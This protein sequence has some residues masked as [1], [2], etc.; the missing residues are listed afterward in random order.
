MT[1][2]FIFVAFALVS[3][4]LSKSQV[5]NQIPPPKP[6]LTVS[7]TPNPTEN[8][9]TYTNEILNISLSHPTEWKLS[10]SISMGYPY[11]TI[12]DPVLQQQP[13]ENGLEPMQGAF[14]EIMAEEFKAVVP[15]DR[16]VKGFARA[17]RAEDG[18]WLEVNTEE[19]NSD[20]WGT[21]G[22]FF[23]HRSGNI[24]QHNHAVLINYK[25]KPVLFQIKITIPQVNQ[26]QSNS[27]ILTFNQILSTFRFLDDNQISWG[28]AEELIQSCEVTFV[29]QTHNLDVEITL[30]D[31]RII[32]A[33]EPRIDIVWEKI[34][35]VEEKCGKIQFV[36]E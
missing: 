30:K 8:W 5:Q 23:T 13:I 21:E 36:T 26:P 33:K 19:S 3:A 12:S 31:G 6:T 2:L 16:Y 34:Q 9:K 7:P 11:I 29:G 15:V 22:Y 17:D 32:K 28:E 24:L 10:E 18:S 14:L 25:T 27:Y 20:V 35:E 4:L 1:S